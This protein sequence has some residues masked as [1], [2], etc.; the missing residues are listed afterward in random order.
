MALQQNYYNS[1]FQITIYN[2]YWKIE[3]ENGI[4]GGKEKLRVRIN[5]FKNKDI[6]DTNQDKY[7]DYDFDFTPDLNSQENFIAQAYLYAKS[8]QFFSGAVDV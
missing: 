4:T 6:A 1:Q 3:V 2:C 5:C 7:C 8:L